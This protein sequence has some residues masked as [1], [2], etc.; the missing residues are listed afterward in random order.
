MVTAGI[1]SDDPV[2]LNLEVNSATAAAVVA[3]GHDVLHGPLSGENIFLITP[4]L[5]VRVGDNQ[6][7]SQSLSDT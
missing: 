7:K 2:L 5:F 3:D 1:G 6:Q 4:L